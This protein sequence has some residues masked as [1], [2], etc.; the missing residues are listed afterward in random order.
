[1]FI[2]LLYDKPTGLKMHGSTKERM[3]KLLH[4]SNIGKKSR[5][6]N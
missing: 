2:Y 5:F 1:L 6:E 3:N 4:L